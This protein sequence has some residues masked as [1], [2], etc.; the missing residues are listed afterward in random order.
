MEYS[1]ITPVNFSYRA[2]DSKNINVSP[3]CD[4]S[5]R[6]DPVKWATD[7]Q[8][9]YDNAAMPEY[10][11]SIG[12]PIRNNYGT[13]ERKNGELLQQFTQVGFHGKKFACL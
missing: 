4:L 13:E 3:F 5:E 2:C 12:S 6:V 1:Y 9:M 7:V 11:K 10:V 8:K